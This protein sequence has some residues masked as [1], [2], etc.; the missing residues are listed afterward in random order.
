[1]EQSEPAWRSVPRHTTCSPPT[2]PIVPILQEVPTN[3]LGMTSLPLRAQQALS[4]WL[5]SLAPWELYLTLTYDPKRYPNDCAPPSSWAAR[6]HLKRFYVQASEATGCPTFL[7]AGLENTRAGWP[8][9]HGLLA[10]GNLA[11]REFALLSRFWYEAR[12][13]ALFARI[14]P[15]TVDA[16]AAYVSKYLVKAGSE[17][18]LLG[19]WQT[20]KAVLQSRF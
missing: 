7:A 14:Q 2:T 5:P 17:I 3:L 9:W 15:G 16:V 10:C 4:T 13:F 20:R 8:H 6:R 1:M 11:P 18:E 19:S 12:G